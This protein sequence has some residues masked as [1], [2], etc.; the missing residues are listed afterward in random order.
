MQKRIKYLL[1]RYSPFIILFILPFLLFYKA[2]TGNTIVVGDFTGSDLLDLHLP[3]KQILHRTWPQR[4]IPLWEPDLSL[5]FPVVGEGQ[6]GPFYPPNIIFSFL[7]PHL[8]LALS[9]VSSF[10]LAALFSYLYSRSI[11]LSRFSSLV[12]ALSFTFSA[13]FVTRLKHVNLIAVSAWTPFL[14]WTAKKLFATRKLRFAA[15][16]ALGLNMQFLAGHPQ[17]TFFS[18][19]I[20]L[21][22]FL[23]EAGRSI[24]DN[25]FA[26]AFPL[27]SLS[28][29][30]TLGLGIGLSAVQILPTLEL[31]QLTQRQEYTLQTASAYPFHPKNLLTLISPYYLGNPATGSYSENIRL[32]GVFWENASYIGLLPLILALWTALSSLIK[33]KQKRFS[34]QLFFLGL[35]LLSLL[36]MLG[37]FTPLFSTLW[38]LVPGFS[39][40]RFPTR[41][42]LFLIFSLSIL[43]GT[44]AKKL[45]QKLMSLKTKAS[46]KTLTDPEEARLSWPLTALQTKIAIAGF[47]LVD[48]FVF[49]SSY[50]DYLPQDKFLKTP[51]TAE[52]ILQDEG[53]FRIYSL[54]QYNQSPYS[55]LGWKNQEDAILGIRKAIPPNNNLL[56]NLSSFTDRGWFEGGLGLR[57]RNRLE[58]FLIRENQN[59]VLTGKLLGTYNVKYILSFSEALGIEINKLEEYDLGEQFASPLR[60]FENHQVMPRTY[61]VPEAEVTTDPEAVF[62]KLVELEFL[63]TK[64]VIL[65]KPPLELPEKFAGALD[66]FRADNPVE[67]TEYSDTQVTIK[68][69]LKNHGFLVLSDIFYP[70]WKAQVDGQEQD[71]LR[72]NYLV[73]ALELWPGEHQIRFYYDPPLFKAGAII[74]FSCLAITLAAALFTTFYKRFSRSS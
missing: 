42:N 73:R 44:G 40:F 5:G 74:S 59:A 56:Y 63:P 3:F 68:T 60:L 47:I 66:Q 25:G 17:M 71:I 26:V 49:A 38:Q 34:Y 54:T 35:S 46:K 10:I 18:L 61:F 24:K 27:A 29:L 57:R 55:A 39:L 1:L 23:F 15:L 7:P 16:A 12:A 6:S 43:A 14:F 70:G 50:I 33:L 20:F 13:F 32:T 48:L 41:F 8:G 28:L 72:A 9:I 31:T 21:I 64:T 19:F 65:E 22:Y 52:R 69:N 11:N 62:D 30:I 4:Q 2:F 51:E 67:I 58:N 37:R 53:S 45:V 36:L